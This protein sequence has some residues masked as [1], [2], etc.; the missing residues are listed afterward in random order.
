MSAGLALP[1]PVFEVPALGLWVKDDSVIGGNKVRKLAHTIPDA[2]AK[3][4]RTVLTFGAIGSNHC[5]ATAE[6][7]RD[8]GLSCICVL[9]DQP[10]D[11]HVRRNLARM[12]TAGA[13]TVL[14]HGSGRA[15]LAAAALIARHH[16]YVLPVGG[17]S[18]LGIRGFAQAGEEVVAQVA[19]GELPEPRTVVIAVGSG[20]SAVGL[21]QSSL[22]ARIVGVVVN[23]RSKFKTHP[24][25]D[26]VRDFL[27]SGYG[28]PT[29]QGEA[30][31]ARAAA[32]GLKLEPVY[33]AK[34]MAAALALDLEPPVLFWNTYV[35]APAG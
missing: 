31:Q 32:A 1:T 2:R 13:R 10:E 33:T 4:K 3:G 25:V 22:T 6:A 35:G 15:A 11:E 23:D 9:V 14:A 28:H 29:P 27:G 34:A 21:A 20:G 5:V 26:Y 19:A 8:A 30:A 12:R 17:S 16:P 24:R 18:A 7:C